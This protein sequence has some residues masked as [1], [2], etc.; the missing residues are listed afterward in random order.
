VDSNLNGD[1]APDRVFVN[2]AGNRNLGT[3]AL[4]LTNSA[5]DTVA[6]AAANPNAMFVTAPNG[7]LPNGGRSLLNLSPIHNIDLTLLKRFA[8]TERIELEFS[9]RATNIFNHPQYT[10]GYLND[11]AP[12]GPPGGVGGGAAIN[13]GPRPE[14]WRGLQYSLAP[15]SSASGARHFRAIRGPCNWL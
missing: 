13:R 14:T 11:V 6:Y 3:P 10:G 4:P 2:P 15:Q 7:T 8:I 9:A 5:G 12:F 1:S